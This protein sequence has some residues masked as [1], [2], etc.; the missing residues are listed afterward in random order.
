MNKKT[1]KQKGR[2]SCNSSLLISDSSSSDEEIQRL[3]NRLRRRGH[4]RTPYRLLQLFDSDSSSSDNNSNYRQPQRQTQRQPERRSIRRIIPQR[5]TR[6]RRILNN[7]PPR[8]KGGTKTNKK[9]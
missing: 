3:S 6:R 1:R 8:A 7:K 5:R 2:G 9:I 4:T